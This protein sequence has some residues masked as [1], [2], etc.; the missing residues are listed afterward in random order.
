VKSSSRPLI[1]YNERLAFQRRIIIVL[2]LILIILI[3]L[4]LNLAVPPV[5][6]AEVPPPGITPVFAIYGWQDERL[7]APNAVAT[8]ASGKI[9][10]TDT[11]NHRIAVFN[12][13]GGYLYSFGR[14]KLDP[15][16]KRALPGSVVFPSGIAVADNGDIYVTS[17][18][19]STL[20]V[21]SNRGKLKRE[22]PVDRPIAVT[23][24]KEKVYVST[25]GQ[26]WVFSLKGE[27]LNRFGSKGRRLAEF[28]YPAGLAVDR[29]GYLFVS[30]TNNNRIQIFTP[31]GELYAYK[32]KP[33][34]SLN[35]TDRYFGLNTG[36]VFDSQQR[37]YVVDTFHHSIRIFDHDGNELAEVGQEGDAEG[38]FNYPSGIAYL[39]GSLFAVADKWNDRVQVV[40]VVVPQ[41]DTVIKRV[42]DSRWPVYLLL[43]LFLVILLLIWQRHRRQKSLQSLQRLKINV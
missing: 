14:L 39:G 43:V 41:E 34:K 8:D 11:R 4:Y 24:H 3:Y 21:F 32:G 15:K 35:D 25:P 6:L 18:R 22:V 5:P 33:P 28:E 26:I 7:S 12:R 23:V 36:L 27:L 30:D 10:V 9:Y 1:P 13:S 37:L 40:R 16:T 20:M 31:R 29:Q 38:R 42:V 17:A 19:R 2:T